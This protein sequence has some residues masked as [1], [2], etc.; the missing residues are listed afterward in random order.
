MYADDTSIHASGA[1]VDTINNHLNDHLNDYASKML[2][3]KLLRYQKKNGRLILNYACDSLELFDRLWWLTFYERR[4]LI[5]LKQ[6]K[7]F[8]SKTFISN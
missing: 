6:K 5:T 7:T 4:Y 3:D 2:L 8:I 1:D